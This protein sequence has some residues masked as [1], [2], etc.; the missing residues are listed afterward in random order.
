MNL[1]L[2]SHR[3]ESAERSH[4]RLDFVAPVSLRAIWVVEQICGLWQTSKHLSLYWLIDAIA[5]VGKTRFPPR[6]HHVNAGRY[7]RVSKGINNSRASKGK[8]QADDTQPRAERRLRDRR[9]AEE[10]KPG[11]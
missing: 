2:L 8:Q 10:A 4:A 11:N 3:D 5:M 9:R 7:S 6:I 1:P